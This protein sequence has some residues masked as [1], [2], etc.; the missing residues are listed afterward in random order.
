MVIIERNRNEALQ[1]EASIASTPFGDC[2]LAHA[3]DS[4]CHLSFLEEG[5]DPASRIHSYWPNADI[6]LATG[7]LTS[8]RPDSHSTSTSD[9]EHLVLY[10]PSLTLCGTSF[11][12]AVWKALLSIPRGTT[13]SYR[14]LAAIAGHPTA[15]RAV[16]TAIGRNPIAVIIPCHRVIRADGSL[17]NYHWG[18]E[19]K[20]R[21]IEWES[22]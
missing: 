10:A 6:R 22:A 3:G 1:L 13:V 15:T 17:G 5:Q 11:Q 21:L 12:L 16:G 18:S 8:V 20:R 7:P 2:L 9:I 19:R 4:L 14:Q